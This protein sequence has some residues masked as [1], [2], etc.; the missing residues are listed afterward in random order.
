MKIL[1][2]DPPFYRIIGFYNRYFPFGLVTLATFLKQ[3]GYNDVGVYDA[4]YNE[5][6]KDID[7]SRL[8]EKYRLYLD[9]FADYNHPVWKEVE[10][11]I[12][13]ID[14]DVIGISIWTT[15][16]AAS[17]F[18]AQIAKKVKP[19]STV[20]MGGPH[21]S[22]KADEI[23]HICSDVDYIIRGEG[24]ILFLKLISY[25]DNKK[26]DLNSI[27]GCSYRKGRTIVH[28]PSEV[29]S[30]N[31][32]HFPYPD[33][34]LLMNENSYNSEDMGLIMS[35]RGCPFSCTYCA[36][37]TKRVSFRSPYHIVKEIIHVKSTYR[38]TQ[39][40]F[41]DDSFTVNVKKVEELCNL[42]ISEKIRI[43]W[44]CN[45]RVNLVNERLLRLMKKAG[46]NFIKVGIESGSE[47]V[48]QKMNKKI[49]LVEI[50]EA[51]RL[52][53]KVGIHWTGYF[54]MGIPG[55]TVDDVHK[56]IDLLFET[57]PDFASLGV[58]EPFPGTKMFED[59]IQ[60][61]LIKENFTLQ[62]FFS[63][64]PNNYYKAKPE[65]QTDT[66]PSDRFIKL[67]SDFKKIIYKYNRGIKRI[68]SMGLARSRIYINEPRIFFEDFKKLLSY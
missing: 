14:P 62:D 56:T 28:N 57:E 25:L 16:A 63:V 3:N 58:Y 35:T 19:K 26:A 31:L 30:I 21:A 60:R 2:I 45:T 66:I 53:R 34:S 5:N 1:L 33:R 36:T 52:F 4:D 42:L 22:V 18:T 24:E 50:R 67:E 64:L 48:L 41:K 8:P 38:T 23:L 51:A 11:T 59:G 7:Y 61:G 39:F 68:L 17:I 65:Q 44:E 15:F 12:Q 29:S 37:N 20:V 40:T 9:S 10:E 46:C 27:S 55:E 43:N 6:P 49:T 13:R 54:M 47:Q 32:N